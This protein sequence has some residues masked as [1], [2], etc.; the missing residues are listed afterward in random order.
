MQ[1]DQVIPIDKNTVRAD[2]PGLAT[3]TLFMN[4][5]GASLMPRPVITAMQDYLHLETQVGGYETERVRADHMAQL[6]GEIAK[7]INA[8][9]DNI[10]FSYSAMAAYTQALSAIPFQP[11]DV[12]LTTT[13]DY[14][15]NQLAFLSM[16]QRLGIRLIRINDLDNGDLDLMHLEQ[17]IQQHHPV[18]VAITHI[19]TNSGIVQPAELI[20]AICSRYDCWY[21]LDAA[22]SA[23][24]LPL[25]V[26]RI[27]AD[28]LVA[29][30]RKF[31]RGP[32][33]TG[34]LYVSDKVLATGLTPLFVDRQGADWTSPDTFAVRANAKRFEPQ[35]KSLS[36]V[37][38]V[39]AVRYANQLGI[40]AIA[41]VNQ[42]LMQRLRTGLSQ[43]DGIDLTDLG[44]V[45]SNILTFH[46]TR[47][48]LATLD[49]ALR[50]GGVLFT[51]Q[52]KQGAIIDFTR[53]GIDW[54]IRLAPHY[55][56]TEA[57]IDAVVELVDQA[58]TLPP[59]P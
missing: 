1:T 18:L 9:P 50:Q 34:F 49:T 6:Y 24:Q 43:I 28:F 16:Q 10:A 58:V 27:Q 53:K 33:N 37:G 40:E 19:P 30:G 59:A 12:I 29:T 8:R 42:V 3:A 47:Q 2:T 41:Q 11:G 57:E 5:A 48:P 22:Q 20:G 17:L 13:N 52:H 39:E 14:I 23:G 45:Q 4:S 55:F 26:E 56:N 21:L 7:L 15:S 35:E 51:V 38:L 31:L 44:S 46:S 25:D 32:R 54:I 36:V